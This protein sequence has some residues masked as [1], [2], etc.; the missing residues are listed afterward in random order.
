MKKSLLTLVLCSFAFGL[1]F[2]LNNVA[3]SNAPASK[4][5]YVNVGKLLASSKSIKLNSVSGITFI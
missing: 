5:A 4:V 3:F 2:G 1:G